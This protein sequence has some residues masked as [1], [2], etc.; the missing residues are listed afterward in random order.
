M[1]SLVLPQMESINVKF[2]NNVIQANLWET[3]KGSCQLP[4]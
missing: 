2:F 3:N 4:S 1:I